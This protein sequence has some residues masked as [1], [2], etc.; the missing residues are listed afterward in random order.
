MKVYTRKAIA[1]GKV[2]Y[3]VVGRGTFYVTMYTGTAGAEVLSNTVTVR[4]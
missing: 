2:E 3:T 4:R 1:A